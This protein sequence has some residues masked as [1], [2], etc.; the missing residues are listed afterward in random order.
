MKKNNELD[1]II[2]WGIFIYFLFLL[3]MKFNAIEDRLSLPYLIG[4]FF[5]A[6]FACLFVVLIFTRIIKRRKTYSLKKLRYIKSY[7]E[8]APF[9]KFVLLLITPNF[10]WVDYF[11]QYIKKNRIFYQKY[12]IELNNF[13][14]LISLLFFW[15][16][17]MLNF[18]EA[19]SLHKNLYKF[20][21]QIILGFAEYRVIS[22]SIEIIYAFGKDVISNKNNS[23]LNSFMRI[24]LAIKSYFEIML[25]YANR[26]FLVELLAKNDATKFPESYLHAFNKSFLI[27]TMLFSS[28]SEASFFVDLQIISVL[29]LVILSIAIYAGNTKNMRVKRGM[30]FVREK[31]FIKNTKRKR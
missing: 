23:G 10:F 16:I 6:G 7:M 26:F 21:F 19:N 17:I 8:D 14:I 3:I 11:K 22:R 20:L 5:Y 4:I 24:G 15:V 27:N 30:F 1:S 29:T 25:N 2:A 9:K 13:N 12:L 28:S 31:I 18:F